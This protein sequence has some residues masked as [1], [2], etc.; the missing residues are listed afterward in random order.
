MRAR[1]AGKLQGRTGPS[2]PVTEH[3]LSPEEPAGRLLR[4]KSAPELVTW[5]ADEQAAVYSAFADV[6][7]LLRTCTHRE[8]GLSSDREAVVGPG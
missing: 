8:A 7:G 3:P 2:L 1:T 4:L 6:G 5:L